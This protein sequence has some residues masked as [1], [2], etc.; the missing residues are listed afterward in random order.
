MNKYYGVKDPSYE[1][2]FK[3]IERMA[4]GA[5]ELLSRRRTPRL[6]PEFNTLPN[7]S[8]KDC[9]QR[10]RVTDPKD[11]LQEIEDEKEK[12]VT[13]TCNWIL[14]PQ[15]KF[16]HWANIEASQ[17]L[18]ISGPPG[19][20]K[21]MIATFI[22]ETIKT[23]MKNSSNGAFAYFFC[24]DKKGED[25]RMPAAILRSLIWQLLLQNSGLF[26]H[27]KGDFQHHER[28]RVFEEV[29][30][31]FSTM[32][33]V[34]R[35]M[36]RDI[37][38]QKGGEVFI[39][40]D[41]FD[42]CDEDSHGKLLTKIHGLFSDQ[43]ELLPGRIKFLLTHRLH[44][45]DIDQEFRGLSPSVSAYLEIDSND[46]K[47]DVEEYIESKIHRLITRKPD[48][49]G[50]E[51]RI[52][53]VL[54]NGHGG[55]FLWVS[56]MV[57]EIT[58]PNVLNF[59]VEELLSRPP[60]G[61]D[62]IYASILNRIPSENQA[63]A[64]FILQCMVAAKRPLT[65]I[66][67]KIAFATFSL[68]TKN[69][70]QSKL[71]DQNKLHEYNDVLSACSSILILSH[72]DARDSATVSFCHQTVKDFLLNKYSR[73]R[74]EWYLTSNETANV[75]LFEICWKYL[76]AEGGLLAESIKGYPRQPG[77]GHIPGG[78]FS[79]GRKKYPTDERWNK[80]G[81]RAEAKVTKY[82]FLEYV[83]S[84]WQRHAMSSYPEVQKHLAPFVKN[85]PEL[86]DI[87]FLCAVG[88][89]KV[90]IMQLLLSAKKDV[91]SKVGQFR[92]SPLSL[93]AKN[94]HLDAVT[95][96][97]A[98]RAETDTKDTAGRTPLSYAAGNGHVDVVKRLL[99]TGKVD[100]ES[101][102]IVY[103]TPLI[104]A[105]RGGHLGAVKELLSKGA[106]I[107]WK[108]AGGSTALTVAS[109]SGH[110]AVVEE[111]RARG[112]KFEPNT[113]EA[114]EESD[115]EVLPVYMW[116]DPETESDDGA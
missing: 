2:V 80:W 110:R 63:P 40:I 49:K 66:E 52:R 28:K 88:A 108:T 47:H 64:R 105:A 90:E 77:R 3:Q 56:L 65:K 44:I 55:T 9:L 6:I 115:A 74:E 100:I 38:A 112:A 79:Q 24:D 18:R 36:V 42:E 34:F 41:A 32:W 50:S 16:S 75:L 86:A 116:S 71:H 37:Q 54:R 104:W 76:T 107:D 72:Q 46:I 103:E 61:L 85:A 70:Q 13:H 33:R 58:R 15:G 21:T 23:R 57:A 82:V 30:Q 96:L 97:L 26:K 87:W 113:G 59:R 14:T 8:L 29:F 39:L 31:N 53:H 45:L 12:R 89:G 73:T 99:A 95:A 11:I 111:L 48:L 4:R 17:L 106:N 1:L 78:D 10:M 101:R 20:G 62:G 114:L 94:G 60:S 19:I 98:E 43:P 5:E 7:S 22:V 91:V 81:K 92:I 109:V 51:D 68:P 27:L 69:I 83:F 102:S 84:M 35:D 25:R 93:A 67:M